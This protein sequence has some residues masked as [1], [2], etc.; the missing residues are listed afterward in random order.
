MTTREGRRNT[1]EKRVGA[2]VPTVR[3]VRTGGQAKT[4]KGKMIR[5]GDSQR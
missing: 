3:I 1:I 2:A 5:R 4:I